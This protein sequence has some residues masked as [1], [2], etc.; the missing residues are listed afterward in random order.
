MAL[1]LTPFTGLCGFIPLDQIDR[2]LTATPEFA[3]LIPNDISKR[4]HD[5]SSSQNYEGLH[6]K[7]ALKDVFASLM[8]ADES[9][10]KKELE[11]LT[12]RLASG[13]VQDGEE[14]LKD[15]ILR[16]NEQFP[17]DIG[18]FCPF[19]LN[20]VKLS[21][22]EAMFLGAGEPH[23]YVSG[24]TMFLIIYL[25]IRTITYYYIDIMECMANSDNVIR[26][27]LTP[28]LRDI[29]N[30]IS[31]LTYT[32]SV[33]S[34]HIVKPTLFQ[35]RSKS[36][37]LYNPPVPEFSVLKVEVD[38]GASEKHAAIDGPSIAIVTR[39]EGSVSWGDNQSSLKLSKGLV[40]FIGKG[41]EV[42]INSGQDPTS[43]LV[44]F[45]AYCVGT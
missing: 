10:I 17:G 31:G 43:G 32:A 24:G 1:A 35:P 7:A 37:T 21:P 3:A 45:R 6:E 9:R 29:P 19:M 23:A 5:V 44:I 22:G 39:G 36:T 11:R 8:T 42:E 28:K 26:A 13:D 16:L 27:G 15:L 25:L 38:A 18:V 41:V 40:F 20:Y 34:K 12:K 14:D 30:L 2:H 4:F 33:P